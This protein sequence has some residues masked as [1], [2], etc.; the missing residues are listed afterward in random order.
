M[1]ISPSILTRSQSARSQSPL[2]AAFT[3]MEMMLVLAIIALL[4]AIGAVTLGEVDENAKFT[5]AE[6]QMN[7][8]KVA[9]SQYKTLNRGLPAKLEDLVTPPGNARVKRKLA[10][11][12]AIIDPWGTKY[13]YRSPGKKS[14][15]E[16]YS[17]GPDKKE[18][19]DDVFSD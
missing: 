19:G 11:E 2:R 7:T 4:I 6:A 9:V 14:A 10:E 17:W 5:A 12:N 3:L 15:Y 18:G 13:Q 16:I 1:K 8:L